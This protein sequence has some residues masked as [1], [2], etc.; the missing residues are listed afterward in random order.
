MDIIEISALPNGGHRNQT[1]HGYLPSGWAVIPADM[2]TANFPFGDVEV[3]EVNGVMTV[4]KWIAG[5]M[6]DPV[7]DEPVSA[8]EPT[9]AD[10]LDV[11][12]GVTDDE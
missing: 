4:T 3:T 2:D 6:P 9:V 12:L 5:T 10:L 1:Y 8:E 11:L 7:E